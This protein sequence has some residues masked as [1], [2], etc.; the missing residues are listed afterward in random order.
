LGYKI[1]NKYG[2]KKWEKYPLH[3]SIE[4]EKKIYIFAETIVEDEG[5]RPVAVYWQGCL[6]SR[7]LDL[8]SPHGI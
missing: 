3:Y 2:K 1:E 5:S 4:T 6:N 8:I 7:E